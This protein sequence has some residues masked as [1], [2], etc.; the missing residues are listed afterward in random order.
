MVARV[1]RRWRAPLRTSGDAFSA[2]APRQS[3][4]RQAAASEVEAAE[5][6]AAAVVGLR[7]A[8]VKGYL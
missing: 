4:G 6:V 5:A 2:R 7:S 3:A 1:R 8:V